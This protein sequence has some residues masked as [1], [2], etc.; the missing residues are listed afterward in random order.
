MSGEWGG[1]DGGGYVSLNAIIFW[2]S[3]SPST[4]A[5]DFLVGFLKV[6]VCPAGPATDK[7][8]IATARGGPRAGC[9]CRQDRPRLKDFTVP[10][11]KNAEV[12]VWSTVC[13]QPENLPHTNNTKQ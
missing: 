12:P 6:K 13:K 9:S 4:N 3:Y 2:G 10:G 11:M 1:R 5:M 8:R 7:L